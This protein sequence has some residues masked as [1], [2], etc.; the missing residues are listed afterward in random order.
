MFVHIVRS[1]SSPAAARVAAHARL[2]VLVSTWTQPTA[3]VRVVRPALQAQHA[4]HL[5]VA[6]PVYAARTNHFKGKLRVVI[7]L[8]VITAPWIMASV[9]WYHVNSANMGA[10]ATLKL[11]SRASTVL[12]ASMAAHVHLEQHQESKRASIV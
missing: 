5:V 9:R 7:A 10:T 12:V 8:L 6:M 4:V 3:H 11:L 1:A 2:V